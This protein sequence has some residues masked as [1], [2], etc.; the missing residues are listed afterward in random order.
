MHLPIPPSVGVPHRP[1]L[2]ST[3]FTQCVCVGHRYAIPSDVAVADADSTNVGFFAG[4]RQAI[5]V[6]R[7]FEIFRPILVVFKGTTGKATLE[8]VAGGVLTRLVANRQMKLAPGA[9]HRLH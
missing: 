2:E 1:D 4:V 6:G 3:L 8:P 5:D 9:L 7:K